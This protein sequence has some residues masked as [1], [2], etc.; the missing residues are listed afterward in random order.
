MKTL[1]VYTSKYGATEECAKQ[2][3][4]GLE[5]QVERINLLEGQPK[6]LKSFDK[7]IL[8]TP[9]YAGN[10][11]K[12]IKNF[13][14]THKEELAHKKVG[15]FI[16]CL[17]LSKV[18]EYIKLGFGEEGIKGLVIQKG[19]GGILDFKKLNFFERTICKLICKKEKDREGNPLKITKQTVLSRMDEGAIEEFVR[20]MNNA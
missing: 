18:E 2:I 17:D 5:G 3:D 15:L 20:V 12:E 19:C 6:D 11:S 13:Y 1:V 4:K 8:G 14:E 7:V 9:I 16:S 10:M